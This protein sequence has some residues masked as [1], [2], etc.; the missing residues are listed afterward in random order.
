MRPRG[1]ELVHSARWTLEQVIGPAVTDPLVASYLR[2][3]EALLEQAEIRFRE[4]W[5][6][7]LDE[8]DDLRRLLPELTGYSADLD[9]AVATAL[10]SDSNVDPR[11]T[12]LELLERHVACLR[13][14]VVNAT[15]AGLSAVDGYL[16]RQ[17]ARTERCVPETGRPGF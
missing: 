1:D 10:D 5:P 16:A 7:L 8:L 13:V 14:P 9:R 6:T 3:V 15:R 2:A 17:A 11:T 12:N 4:E